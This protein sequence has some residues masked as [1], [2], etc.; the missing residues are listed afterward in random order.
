MDMDTAG[1]IAVLL[2]GV[3]SAALIAK[4]KKKK[5]GDDKE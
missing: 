4:S 1:V 5:D 2:L 3:S